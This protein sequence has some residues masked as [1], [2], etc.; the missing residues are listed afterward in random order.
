MGAHYR[1]IGCRVKVSVG[2]VS[3]RLMT[4]PTARRAPGDAAWFAAGRADAD[5]PP[6]RRLSGI[7]ERLEAAFLAERETWWRL[8]RAMQADPGAGYA[9]TPTCGAFGSD[10][11]VMLAWVRVVSDMV[12]DSDPA[13]SPVV[14]VCDDPWLFRTL[15]KLDGVAAAG[16][17]PPLWRSAMRLRV[18]GWLAR[19]KVAVTC[20]RAA[21]M[22]RRT[23]DRIERGA[24]VLLVYGHPDSTADGYDAYFAH[25]M[26][27]E[28]QT[29]RLLHTDCPAGR[30]LE[31][32]ADGRTAALHAWGAAVFALGGLFCRWRPRAE[33][34]FGLLIAR[35]AALENSGGGP[36][37]NRWQHHCQ[38]AFLADRRPG[39]V[40]WPWE[41]HGWERAFVHAARALGVRTVGYQHTAVGPF[42]INH[43]PHAAAD[44]VAS[45]PDTVAADGP[46]YAA[47]LEAWGVPP[48]RMVDAGALRMPPLPPMTY[49]P[50]APVLVLMSAIR[51]A[52]ETQL[53][54]ARALADRGF[55]V[56]VKPHP[57]YDVAVRRDGNPRRTDRPLRSFD[58]LAGIVYSTGAS[59][60]EAR[61]SG[62]PAIHLLFEDRVAFDVVPGHLANPSATAETIVDVFEDLD[63][64]P[65]V[66]W[67]EVFSSPDPDL[68]RGLLGDG[69]RAASP[70]GGS[71]VRPQ[72]GNVVS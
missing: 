18:R 4:S 54:A 56:L 49:D 40:A 59:G 69:I 22:T 61:L 71:D 44:G 63:P 17:P 42:Q 13:D 28:P 70:D 31:L 20:L 51:A 3:L 23:R 64:A 14:C 25:L 38:A 21:R 39:V 62:V 5:L 50:S 35:A 1:R 66:A 52:A 43:S 47:E 57:M 2:S 33:G 46:A 19:L 29:R 15:A 32:E 41:N 67:D 30:A 16:P 27:T 45:L 7:A 48:D 9:H 58:R 11:G 53:A 10:F 55:D 60:I 36:A 12:A 68:W 37:M 24:P 6:E 65:P 72:R 8:G 26:T 34:R